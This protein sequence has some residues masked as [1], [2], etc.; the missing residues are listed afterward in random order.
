MQHKLNP[1]QGKPHEVFWFSHCI[2]GYTKHFCLL[3]LKPFISPQLLSIVTHF[4]V[5]GLPN[6]SGKLQEQHG[7]R[8]QG[9]GPRI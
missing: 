9:A 6:L 7:E 4:Q 2:V 5:W 3:S 8:R 1:E